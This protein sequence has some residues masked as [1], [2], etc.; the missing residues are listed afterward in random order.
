MK[1]I[2]LNVG[3][4]WNG[5]LAIREKYL[6][7]AN[8]EGADILIRYPQGKLLIPNSEVNKYH[9]ISEKKFRDN[10]SNELHAL[11]YYKIP[12]NGDIYGT[13]PITDQEK[14]QEPVK[15]INTI[16]KLKQGKLF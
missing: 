6:K 12:K 15:L 4:K 2:K 9:T 5:M 3:S 8:D 11:V 10:F 1:I 16:P 7:Q 13:R 14:A